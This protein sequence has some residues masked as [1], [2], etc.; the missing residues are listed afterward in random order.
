MVPHPHPQGGGCGGRGGGGGGGGGDC[1]SLAH[2]VVAS[3]STL[4][5]VLTN[6]V[7]IQL[8]IRVSIELSLYAAGISAKSPGS[9]RVIYIYI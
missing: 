7:H 6:Y 3:C 1:R 8:N 9:K 2:N 4:N 5:N